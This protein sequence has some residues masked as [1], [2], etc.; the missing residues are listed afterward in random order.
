MEYYRYAGLAL[1]PIHVGTGEFQLGRVDNLI[2]REPGTQVPK[3]PGSS[4]AGVA[5]AYA[6]MNKDA[7]NGKEFGTRYLYRKGK[8]TKSC[9][10]KGGDSGDDH[11]GERDCPVC[12]AF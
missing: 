7:P 5:R 4:I 12:V 2:V 8:D 9:A 1:D 3:I 11:C 6:A 10:G